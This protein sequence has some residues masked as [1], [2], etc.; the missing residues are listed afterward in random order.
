[1]PS[2]RAIL[3]IVGAYATF[4][5]LDAPRSRHF[6]RLGTSGPRQP[7]FL[8]ACPCII[9]SQ[10]SA[11]KMAKKVSTIAGAPVPCSYRS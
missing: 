6:S 11:R 2:H 1:V 9:E 7:L 4:D 8:I 5:K 10:A 3:Q